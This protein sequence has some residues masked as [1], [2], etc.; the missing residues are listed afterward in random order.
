MDY[1]SADV[2]L[3]PEVFRLDDDLRPTAVSGSPPDLFSAEGQLRGHS[4]YRWDAL[5]RDGFA[6]WTQRMERTLSCVDYVRIDH[7]RGLVAD[8]RSLPGWRRR[9]TAGG[10]WLPPRGSS[11][12]SRGVPLLPGD[13]RDP[14]GTITLDVSEVMHEFGIPGMKVLLLAFED[15]DA[16]WE[17][18]VSIPHN[19]VRDCVSYRHPRHQHRAGLARGRGDGGAPRAPAPGLRPGHPRGRPAPGLHPA[20]HVDGGEHGHRPRAGRARPGARSP[21]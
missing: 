13:R 1:D 9:W 7:F 8:G 15:V 19:V 21:A 16:G 12:R 11:A 4:L 5:R 2:L 3:H 18:N 14:L 10:C 17:R 6:W 20:R